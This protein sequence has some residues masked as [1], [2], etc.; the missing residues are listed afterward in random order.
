M[1]SGFCPMADPRTLN[2]IGNVSFLLHTQPGLR[3]GTFPQG[4]GRDWRPLYMIL[5]KHFAN[6]ALILTL[7]LGIIF[8]QFQKSTFHTCFVCTVRISES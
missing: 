8:K 2:L 6:R 5:M 3:Q 4:L 1:V 7:I